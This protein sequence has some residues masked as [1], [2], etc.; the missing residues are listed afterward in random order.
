MR[1]KVKYLE[2]N[3]WIYELYSVCKGGYIIYSL[4]II[5][6]FYNVFCFWYYCN[7]LIY[8]VKKKKFL[9]CFLSII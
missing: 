3:Y 5:I 6:C 2:K 9:L 1:D 4:Y 7:I 8:V